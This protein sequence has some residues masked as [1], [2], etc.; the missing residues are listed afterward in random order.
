MSVIDS[1]QGSAAYLVAGEWV[2]GSDSFTVHHPFDG[3]AVR[4]VTIPTTGDVERAV[5]AAAAA[6]PV[7][8]GLP[9]HVRATALAQVAQGLTEAREAFARTITAESGKPI[10]WARVEVSRSIANFRTAAEEATRFSGEVVRLDGD[11][12]GDG[13]VGWVRRFPIGPVL[14]ITPFNFPLNLVTHKVAPAL[15]VG[16]PIVVK[17]APQTP[18]TALR[19][20]E[21]IADTELPD[22]SISVLTLPNGP[23]LDAL[24]ADPRLP[25]V[26]FTGSQVGW[27]IKAAHPRKRVLLELG[28]NA[29]AI[30]HRDADIDAAVAG[31]AAG[32]FVQAGQTCI[33]TQR[34]LVHEQVFDEFVSR[35]V[36]ETRALTLGDP[37]DESTFVG[38]LVS[39]DAAAR[40]EEAIRDAVSAGATLLCGGERSGTSVTP[41][42]LT[43]V[44]PD[45]R[46]WREE[47]FGP[48]L[49]LAAYDD[50]A[51]AFRRVNDSRYGLQA[52]IFT[53]DIGLALRAH[54]ELVVGTV[55]VGD[56]PSY[57]ADNLPYGG[58]K[59]SGVGR[60]GVRAAM[61]ELTDRR[62]LVLR[63]L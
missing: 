25:V 58:W 56:S 35:L 45:C 41:A 12:I 10:R 24:V 43:N 29:A 42:V 37:F 14:G 19:L 50:V 15:A 20:A 1:L 49:A 60:E 8:A 2:E 17:P 30:V 40:V 57:R 32:G 18:L 47:A 6:Y 22:G 54:R 59:D 34:V 38:P 33:S 4:D 31:V 28:G 46:V 62:G 39:L 5:A 16:A 53:S 52:G 36:E 23:G 55:M 21:L 48:V 13:R 3:R 9:A 61:D 51:D 11:P 27:S 26:S 7:L 44:P 63:G